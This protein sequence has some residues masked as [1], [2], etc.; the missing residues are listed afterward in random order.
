MQLDIAKGSRPHILAIL[1]L[2]IMAVFVVRLFYLQV[3]RHDFYVSAARE[4]QLRQLVIPAA[5]GEIY[6]MDAGQP[7]KIVMNETVYT[8]FADP[9]I[10]KD[11]QPIIDV[12]QRVAGGNARANLNNLLAKKE[13]RYQVLAT[14]VSLKQAEMIKKENLSGVGFQR[15]TQRVYPEGQ[16]AA[17]AL[18]YVNFEG[19]GQYGLEGAQDERLTG[20]DGLLQTVADVRDVPL[21]IGKE[22]INK[23][24]DNGDNIVMTIDRNIQS[25]AESALAEGL[26]RSGAT[27]G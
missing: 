22:Y 16:L 21:T 23:P 17:Q 26:K 3:V 9:K 18:G 20:K 4:E 19:V 15:D 7:V 8:V 6:A 5:R 11:P 1:V 27:N 2:A 12:I 14:K 10:I 25:Y 24:A 13:S